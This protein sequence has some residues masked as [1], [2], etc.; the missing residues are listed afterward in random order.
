MIPERGLRCE[1]GRSVEAL[2]RRALES[3]TLQ[4]EDVEARRRGDD[5]LRML[6]MFKTFMNGRSA[7]TRR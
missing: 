7:Q 6:R 5:M 2:F 1:V 4:V 3:S